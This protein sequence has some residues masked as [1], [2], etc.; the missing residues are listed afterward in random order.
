MFDNFQA[1]NNFRLFSNTALILRYSFTSANRNN[2]NNI[3][4]I[5]FSLDFDTSIVNEQQ[6]YRILH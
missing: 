2:N 3:S 5:R 6:F 4:S 1:D